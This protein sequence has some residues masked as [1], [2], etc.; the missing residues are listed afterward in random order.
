MNV[1]LKK[2]TVAA[3]GMA[4]AALVCLG[5]GMSQNVIAQDVALRAFPGAVGGGSLAT[6]GRGGEVVHVTN[7]NDSGE[8]SFRDAVSKPGRIV[9][10]DVGGTIE[11]KGDVVVASNITIAGQ[12]APGGG[13]ITLKNNKLGLGGENVICRFL[14]SRPGERGTNA[15]YDAWGGANGANSIVDHCSL[16][17]ANDEQWGLYSKCDNITVQYSVIGPSN[18]FS[19][20]SK[21]IHGFGIMLGRSNATWDHNLIVHNVSRNYRGKVPGTNVTDFTN[22]VIYNW[23]YQTG[24]GTIGHVNYAGNTLKKGVSTLSGMNYMSVGDSGTAPENYRIFLSGN[25]MLNIDNSQF[26]NFS[27]N[28]WAG[29]SYKSESGKNEWN[30]R[31]DSSFPMIVN[32]TDV[33]S[34]YTAESSEAAYEH[35]INFVGNGITSDLRT[36]I[37]RQVAYETKTG[38]G[39]LT[40]A[41]P[42]QEATDEQRATLDKYKI[43]CGVKYE[44]PAPVYQKEI[45]D[46]DNDGM[47]DDWELARGLDPSDPSDT[48][49]DYCGQGYTNIEYYINDLT[50]NA[51]PEGVVTISPEAENKEADKGDINKDGNVDSSDLVLMVRYMLGL[52]EFTD[53]QTGLS[54]VDEDSDVDVMD[55]IL[56]KGIVQDSYGI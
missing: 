55:F 33:S 5:G 36:P 9:V 47:P 52:E 49:G 28:N 45:T 35:V 22:N 18:S 32:G 34:V 11:L 50:V 3:A 26:N 24:Y 7:L 39:T 4:L 23:A 53:E 54:D 44:Y 51:F 48:G 31:F 16:G 21:G 1:K 40:G 46:T 8:G 25:R 15:D 20:H 19:Y 43:K 37:D 56:L 41:R 14:S 2:C 10:F 12:T 42:Y 30:T 6:G 27:Q 13:G 29:I 38:T 17:W